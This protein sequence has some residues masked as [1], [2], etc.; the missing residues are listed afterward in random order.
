[1]SSQRPP[2]IYTSMKALEQYLLDCGVDR[3]WFSINQSSTADLTY[4]L[5][6]Y[7]EQGEAYF[8]E[9]GLKFDVLESSDRHKLVNHFI[10][11]INARL[12]TQA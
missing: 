9:R 1:M 7:G 2:E 4:V 5:L 10:D 11:M 12:D 8:P 6:W 3:Y